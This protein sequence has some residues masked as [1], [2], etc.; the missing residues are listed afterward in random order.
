[1]SRTVIYAPPTVDAFAS[2]LGHSLNVM[3]L[4][5][6]LLDNEVMYY[7]HA[8]AESRDGILVIDSTFPAIGYSIAPANVFFLEGC[9]TDEAWRLQARGRIRSP[10]RW[11]LLGPMRRRSWRERFLLWW[12]KVS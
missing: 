11:S 1:V 7:L 2:G 8:F 6:N 4:H 9:P 3:T 12:Y 10:E 5:R